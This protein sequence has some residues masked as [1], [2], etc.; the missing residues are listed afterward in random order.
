MIKGIIFDLGNVLCSV[1]NQHFI[2]RVAQ[3]SGKTFEQIFNLIYE[4]SKLPSA[5]E[6]GQI[7]SQEFH[8]QLMSLC[9]FSVTIEE[10]KKM[11]SQDKLTV[12]TGMPELVN[13]LHQSFK[14]GLLSNTSVW[15]YEYAVKLMPFL[16]SFDVKT[17]SYETKSM[18]PSPQI[19]QST[20]NLLQL[21]P[22]ECIYVDDVLE[23][24]NAAR[25]LGIDGIQFTGK[26]NFV[27]ELTKRNIQVE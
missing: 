18:K 19:Y 23:Y 24:V 8:T 9:G 7:T 13:Q 6:I 15:D 20:L 2:D 3:K 5:Y 11:Y 26:D 10:M 16:E 14:V 27:Q 12:I 22:Q 17:K 1:T 4:K 25:S 21:S